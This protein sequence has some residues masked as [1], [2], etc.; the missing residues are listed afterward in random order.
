M[1]RS[2]RSRSVVLKIVH[3]VP[4]NKRDAYLEKFASAYA[5]FEESTVLEEVKYLGSYR[6]AFGASALEYE[7]LAKFPSM[8]FYER[9]GR[10]RGPGRLTDEIVAEIRKD[11]EDLEFCRNIAQLPAS[12]DNIDAVIA[13]VVREL[14]ESVTPV[15]EALNE[16]HK[17]AIDSRYE[18]LRKVEPPEESA[19]AS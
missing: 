1:A 2:E 16:M 14:R 7:H 5:R 9:L 19:E 3:K 10:I 18:W 13:D 15:C 11:P 12:E 17:L 8:G 4:V 6:T